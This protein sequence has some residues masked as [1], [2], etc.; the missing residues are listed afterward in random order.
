MDYRGVGL[1]GTH[2]TSSLWNLGIECQGYGLRLNWVHLKPSTILNQDEQEVEEGHRGGKAPRR[3]LVNLGVSDIPRLPSPEIDSTLVQI[4]EWHPGGEYRVL[5]GFSVFAIDPWPSRPP[6]MERPQ[7][8]SPSLSASPELAQ[9]MKADSGRTSRRSSGPLVD[10]STAG[11]EAQDAVPV[12]ETLLSLGSSS[13]THGGPS[14][15]SNALADASRSRHASPRHLDLL[16][17]PSGE[18]RLIHHWLTFTS[19]KL[20]LID[21]PHNPCRIMMLRM[22]LRG[23][24]SC[25]KESSANIAIFHALCASAASNLY[26]LGGR[27]NDRDR[28][29]ALNHEQQAIRHLRNNL[30]QADSH[31]DE[32]FAMAIMACI[33]ADAISGTTQRW[34]THVTGGLAY[35]SRL[36]ARGLHEA[37]VGDFQKHMV[38]MAILCEIPVAQHLKSFLYDESSAESLEFT[39]PYYGVSRSFLRAYDYMNQLGRATDNMTPELERQLDAF[40]LQQYLDF[41]APPPPPG[42]LLASPNQM[43]GLVLFHTAKVFYYARLVFFQRSI[44]RDGLDTVQ[45]LVDLGMQELESIERI[46][47]GELGNMMLWPVI[48]LGAECRSRGMQRR[49]TTWFEKQRKL[50]FRNVAVL[51]ELVA[52]VWAARAGGG[53]GGGGGGGD[54]RNI[55]WRDVIV[56]P[57]FDVFRL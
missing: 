8:G 9:A 1:P 26:E 37:V 40:Q 22:A 19:R 27:A 24:M 42:G 38:S 48:V 21:E 39:F 41:P 36:H 5:G 25:S 13:T 10:A 56:L 51:E 12:A 20:V 46:G 47:R 4:D 43:Q 16:R 28:V 52:T 30:A 14:T 33:T 35:L 23:L 49:M 57:Q 45:S 2:T 15:P 29:L 50:G 53:G 34:R 6:P 18:N 55:D 3:S 17:M 54:A 31:Q 44:R 32:T 7:S 11:A